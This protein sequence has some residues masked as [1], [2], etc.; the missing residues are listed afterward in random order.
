MLDALK[1]L[2][3]GQSEPA[4]KAVSPRA[5]AAAL[6]VEAAFADGV[7]ANLE[8]DMIAEILLDTFGLD[9]DEADA[10]IAEGEDLANEAAGAHQFTKIVKTLPEAERVRL[11]E[12]LYRVVLADGD[13]AAIEE[14]FVR[15]IASL[16]HIDDVQRARARQAAEARQP[17]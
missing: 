14:A 8:S 7:Y 16:L 2:L 1:R 13:K 4:P 6:L 15:H 9:A 10:L 12:A 5:A 3:S 11:V 17:D